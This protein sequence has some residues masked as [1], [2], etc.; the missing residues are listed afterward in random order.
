MWEIKRANIRNGGRCRENPLYEGVVTKAEDCIREDGTFTKWIPERLT[1]E[2]RVSLDELVALCDD[3][4]VLKDLSLNHKM[5]F[6]HG[7]KF[8]PQ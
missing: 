2:Q 4:I 7:L 3:N 6:L 8:D 1:E 5:R